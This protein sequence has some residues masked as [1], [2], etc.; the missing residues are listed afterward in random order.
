MS[1]SLVHSGRSALGLNLS[2]M[3][4]RTDICVARPSE[5]A[6]RN[7]D[8]THLHYLSMNKINTQFPK[9]PTIP[10]PPSPPPPLTHT[11]TQVERPTNKRSLICYVGNLYSHINMFH[12]CFII[13]SHVNRC[14]MCIKS[15][16]IENTC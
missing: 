6:V 7:M 10:L 13:L 3:N 15:I 9:H 2:P 8:D 16:G 4:L 14:E 11:H 1:S 12:C 5:R